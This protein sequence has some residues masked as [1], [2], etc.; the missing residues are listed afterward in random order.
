MD[1]VEAEARAGTAQ[2][3]IKVKETSIRS[4]IGK[5]PVIIRLLNVIPL[6]RK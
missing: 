3:T 5:F 6:S 1:G 4:L 2:Q